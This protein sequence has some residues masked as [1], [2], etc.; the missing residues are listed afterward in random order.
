MTVIVDE[1]SKPD[2]GEL[3]L[4]VAEGDRQA[5]LELY[6]RYASR[7][8][9]LALKMLGDPMR[10]EDISQE[11]FIRLW[12]RA[13]TYRPEKGAFST[14]ILTITRRI[15]IDRF[16]KQSR[17]PE[18]TTSID[19]QNWHEPPDPDSGFESDRWQTLHFLLMELPA[20]QREV[21]Q[22]AYFYGLSQR[23]IAEHTNTPLGTVKTRARLGMDKL[24]DAWFRK[25]DEAE[26]RSK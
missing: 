23:Q 15:V 16:R 26:N 8:Y 12:K 18:I 14:W 1:Q 19:K 20:E 6:D 3:T 25:M 11:A 2:E 5:F 7:V 21:V 22:L 17:R 13:E 24:R 4:L 9:G 10:A